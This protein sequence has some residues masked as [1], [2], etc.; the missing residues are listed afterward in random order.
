MLRRLIK[1][2]FS[3]ITLVGVLL[4]V[5]LAFFLL[6]VFHWTSLFRYVNISLTVISLL[7]VGYIVNKN[8]SPEFKLAWCIPIL[9]FP[10]FGGLLYLVIKI[11]SLNELKKFKASQRAKSLLPPLMQDEAVMAT[12]LSP[13]YPSITSRAR[14]QPSTTSWN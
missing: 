11:Q 4:C 9:M 5:Q 14:R 10:I 6:L 12:F 3:R 8:D 2:I 1:I 13:L 7:V